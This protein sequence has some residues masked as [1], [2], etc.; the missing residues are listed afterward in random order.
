[1]ER[2]LNFVCGTGILPVPDISERRLN[3]VCGTGILPVPDISE[4]RLNLFVEQASCL[5]LKLVKED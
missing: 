5:F 4:R 2:R 1:S 3:F